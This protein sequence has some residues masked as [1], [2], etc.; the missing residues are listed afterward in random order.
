MVR[1]L[2]H[3]V[4]GQSRRARRAH[5]SQSTVGRST[6]LWKDVQALLNVVQGSQ[7]RW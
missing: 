5:A 2:A 7:G 4:E 6:H 1:V 3:R